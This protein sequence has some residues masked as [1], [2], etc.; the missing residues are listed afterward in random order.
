MEHDL[1]PINAPGGQIQLVIGPMFSGKSSELL[2]R[3]R[4]Y[5]IAKRTCMVIKYSKDTR[6]SNDNLATH[7][8]Y[9]TLMKSFKK[10]FDSNCCKKKK[11]SSMDC[12]SC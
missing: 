1:T 10:K 9:V 3:I 5:T 12:D 7:D 4:R 2:R 6:Y 11:K 8:L